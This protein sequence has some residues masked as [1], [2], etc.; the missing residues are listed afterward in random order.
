M[1]CKASPAFFAVARRLDDVIM[2]GQSSSGLAAAED[3]S[4][5]VWT[6][7]RRRLPAAAWE[8]V[9]CFFS[10]PSPTACA[11]LDLFLANAASPQ[12]T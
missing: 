1:K 2:G 9:A 7:G 10:H 8:A 11:R 12:A 5:A 4:G 6:G 3:G